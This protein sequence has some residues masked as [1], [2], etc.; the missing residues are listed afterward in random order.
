MTRCDFCGKKIDTYS[1]GQKI[2]FV[3][4]Y[5]SKYDG[6]FIS[7]DVC[8]KC[9]DDFIDKRCNVDLSGDN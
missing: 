5:G 9:M 8:Y 3:A 1:D 4:C 7:V 6:D 2:Q